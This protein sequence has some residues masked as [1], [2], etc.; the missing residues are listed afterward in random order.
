MPE[1]DLD[2]LM[3]RGRIFTT[4]GLTIRQGEARKCHSNVSGLWWESQGRIRIVTGYCLSEERTWF[5]HRWGLDAGR[6]VETTFVGD[7]Y[8]GV[9]LEEPETFIFAVRNL[10]DLFRLAQDPRRVFPEFLRGCQAFATMHER[11]IGGTHERGPD[12]AVEVAGKSGKTG[13]P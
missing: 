3:P 2:I 6:I 13:P 10:T 1:P 5:Q 8:Y 9:L 12:N 11:G 4:E 7:R